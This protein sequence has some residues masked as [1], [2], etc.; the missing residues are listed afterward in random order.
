MTQLLEH[1]ILSAHSS[2]TGRYDALRLAEILAVS[3]AE[4]AE[5]LGYTPRGLR[6]NPDS[7]R[8]QEKLVR[9]ISLVQRLRE[10]LDGSMEYVRIWLKAPHPALD[11][12]RPLDYIK[13]G[14]IDLIENMVYAFETGQPY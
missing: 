1:T 7:E 9:L 2:E 10:N 13:E 8:L 11:G 5:I 14:R 3:T 6:K 12:S 4:M